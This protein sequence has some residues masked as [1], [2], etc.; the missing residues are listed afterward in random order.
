[1]TKVVSIF[2]LLVIAQNIFAQ[3]SYDER[4]RNYI[5]QYADYAIADQR[6]TGVPAAITLGQG[7]LETDAGNSELVI[8]ANNHFGI[9]CKNNW[10]GETILHTDDA[11]NECFK[12]YKNALESYGDHSR[13][14]IINPR[15]KSLFNYPATNYSKWC[16]GLKRCGYATNPKYAYQL[17]KIIEK[18]DLQDYTYAALDSNYVIN[19]L[20]TDSLNNIAAAED[21]AK[22][23]DEIAKAADSARVA[24]LWNE[25]YGADYPSGLPVEQ[26]DPVVQNINGLK[27]VFCKKGDVL[28]KTAMKYRLRY[29]HLLEINDMEDGPLPFDTYIY[30][31][32]KNT[33][34]LRKEHVV[35]KGESLL[36][37]A[38]NE[39]IQLKRLAGFNHLEPTD[40][41]EEG[42]ILQ[43]Q[44]MAPIKPEVSKSGIKV[45]SGTVLEEQEQIA[46]TPVSVN[47][48]QHPA[49][50]E[51]EIGFGMGFQAPKEKVKEY[52]GE[53]TPTEITRQDFMKNDPPQPQMKKP[54]TEKV[55][56]AAD[57]H[58]R[59]KRGDTAYS[60]AKKNGVT[61]ADLMKW[62]ANLEPQALSIG[63]VIQV[64]E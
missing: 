43:L 54:A 55:Y 56:T 30:L 27:A 48:E 22:S 35:K 42:S 29:A 19:T 18:Y 23:I 61:V 51:E 32:K 47:D 39:G 41:P 1:M 5:K 6:K 9:K 24:I 40:M 50:N 8:E 10:Q 2:F 63:Q 33:T 15:Y 62:N 4:A 53:A 57:K 20:S 46:V 34:G 12:K 16:H 25:K 59:V 44:S 45:Y 21:S 36:K 3:E 58:Y 7:I 52:P 13:H 28:L 60:I 14:L 49:K 11:K 26:E 37:I 31:E 38:Q 17:I 64:R